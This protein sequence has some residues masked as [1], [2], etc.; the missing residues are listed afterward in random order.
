MLLLNKKPKTP[1]SKKSEIKN[2]CFL[3]FYK[4]KICIEKYFYNFF[5]LYTNYKINKGI[6]SRISVFEI[7]TNRLFNKKT[8]N[9]M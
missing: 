1:L 7:F 3:H 8:K 6:K 5:L 2:F 9:F 4:K